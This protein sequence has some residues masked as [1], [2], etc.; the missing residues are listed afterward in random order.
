MNEIF[1]TLPNTEAGEDE[2]PF[3]K[4]AT[5]LTN[6]FTPKKNR[7]YEVYVF[8][9]AKQENG[10]NISAFHTRLRQ[11]AINCEFAD[12]DR[13]I[14]TQIVQNC[15]SHKL[16]MKALQNPE[17]TLTQLLDAGKAMEMSKS[18]AETIE[19]KQ[20]INKLSRKY[21]RRAS[22]QNQNGGHVDRNSDGA[23]TADR[24]SVPGESGK[25]RNCGKGYPHPGGKTSCPAYG[26][27]CRGCGKQ[28]HYEAVCRS[29]KP[30][31]KQEFKPQKPRHNVQNLVDK[32][33]SSKDSDEDGYAFSVN[34]TGKEHS[35]PM[36]NIVIHDTPMTIM[37]DSGASVNVL[38]EKDYQAL[39]KRPE[40]QT[41]KVKIHPYMS[42][43]S[44]K[45]LGKFKTV[46]KFNTKCVED[47]LYVVQG[48]G[49]SLLSWKTSQELG[50]LKA[51]HN[52]NDDSSPTTEKL[53]EEYDELFH[54]LGKLKGY[55]IKLHIDESVPPVA[56]PH[57]RVPF[58]VRQQLEEQLN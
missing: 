56:Q 7:E 9:K 57:R 30:N 12:N 4:A 20:N 41:T 17:L 36:F 5:A 51:V 42:N 52:V 14:K 22:K 35:Q 26:K 53:I 3:E 55:Q 1:E 27:S 43:K 21:T 23:K 15:L 8:R 50:L 33:S 16:R 11:L 39:S 49:G 31:R 18:Q 47:K 25:C 40:L 32:N 48:S 19:E 28:N 29:K 10:E 24:N 34:S 2:D 37:A 54:G 44:L 46:L 13:E 58:H 45:V 38:D 6:Y